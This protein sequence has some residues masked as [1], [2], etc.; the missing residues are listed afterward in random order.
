MH[1]MLKLQHNG[2]KNYKRGFPMVVLSVPTQREKVQGRS[3][4]SE[5]S[6]WKLALRKVMTAPIQAIHNLLPIRHQEHCFLPPIGEH[7]LNSQDTGRVFIKINWATQLFLAFSKCASICPSPGLDTVFLL[8]SHIQPAIPRY[9][10]A[11]PL[12]IY[13][14][15][16]LSSRRGGDLFSVQ[17]CGGGF[18]EGWQQ[19]L[20]FF[21]LALPRLPLSACT[22]QSIPPSFP[23]IRNCYQLYMDRFMHGWGPASLPL[24]V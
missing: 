2:V 7:R 20:G 19:A 1:E 12:V 23:P 13:R 24:I 14:L 4:E 3:L 15:I 18:Q 5:P 6:P 17:A 22:A 10:R 16:F 11:H 8:F 9:T 21:L